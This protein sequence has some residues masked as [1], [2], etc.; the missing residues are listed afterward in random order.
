MT[1]LDATLDDA[2]AGKATDAWHATRAA[3]FGCSDLPALYAILGWVPPDEWG[4]H[5]VDAVDGAG[6][7]CRKWTSD[8]YRVQVRTGEREYRTPRYI[9]EASLPLKR[10]AA[11]GVPKLIAQKA[12]LAKQ[13]ASS[14]AMEEGKRKERHLFQ[15]SRLGRF[16][17]TAWYAP[18]C[19]G[20]WPALKQRIMSADPFVVRDMEEPRLLCT[21]EAWEHA[22]GKR[23]AWELKTDRLGLRTA[24]PWYQKLQAVGQAVVLEAD[25]W[26]IQ[27]GPEWALVDEPAFPDLRDPIQWGPFPVRDDDRMMVRRAAKMGWA[28]VE[29]AARHK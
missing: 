6:K 24:P 25:A 16:D 15:Q 2:I 23:V 9:L 11:N 3:G 19:T 18:D 17:T 22:E 27:Y 29:A 21:I 28:L 26:G 20:L 13:G 1:D 5:E 8:A 14:D 7:P 10:G 4:W 12:G